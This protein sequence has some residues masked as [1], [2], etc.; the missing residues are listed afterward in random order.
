MDEATAKALKALLEQLLIVAA[1]IQAV[2]E[3]AA[4][5]V[6]DTEN[7]DLVDSVEEAVA[8]IV[9]QAEEDREFSRRKKAGKGL[10]QRFAKIEQQMTKLLNTAQTRQLPRTAG[11]VKP[12]SKRVI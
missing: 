4:E 3:P 5:E 10:E 1:G 7:E 2:I 12:S 6:D 9:E 11:A 8:E